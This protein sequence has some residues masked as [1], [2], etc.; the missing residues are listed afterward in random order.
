MDPNAFRALLEGQGLSRDFG[1]SVDVNI[2]GGTVSQVLAKGAALPGR[3][4]DNLVAY[5]YGQEFQ[6]GGAVRYANAASYPIEFWCPSDGA[7]RKSLETMSK[8]QFDWGKGQS[9]NGSV[10]LKQIS[11][12]SG[13]GASY[14]L[15]KA[16]IRDIG[17]INYIL[18]GTGEVVTFTVTFAYQYY[19]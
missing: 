14:T 15:Q 2:G 5:V 10:T 19:E 12:K 11:P 4:I 16:E 8:K 3:N 18:D 6:I 17:P 9:G 7:I 13:A 1:F